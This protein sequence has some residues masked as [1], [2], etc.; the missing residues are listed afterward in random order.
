MSTCESGPDGSA[1]ER[2]DLLQRVA[3]DTEKR[4]IGDPTMHPDISGQRAF[5]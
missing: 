5:R 3:I 2:T 1:L 4:H